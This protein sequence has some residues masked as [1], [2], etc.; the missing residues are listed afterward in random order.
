MSCESTDIVYYS[1]SPGIKSQPADWLSWCSIFSTVL[2]GGCQFKHFKLGHGRFLAVVGEAPYSDQATACT[3]EES[4]VGSL[5]GQRFVTSTVSVTALRPTPW[6]RGWVSDWC[7]KLMTFLSYRD[8]LRVEL[9]HHPPNIV[10]ASSLTH[11]GRGHL[12]CLNARYR[13]F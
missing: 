4:A 1:G 3:T 6:A 8:W 7:V 2:S 9:Y 13:G 10:T 5:E 12:N 11:W